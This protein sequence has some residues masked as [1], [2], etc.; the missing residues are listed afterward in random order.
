[1]QLQITITFLILLV[2]ALILGEWLSVAFVIFIGI[3]TL[4][5]VTYG[6][7]KLHQ[8]LRRFLLG[9]KK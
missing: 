2:F 7:G 3:L 4:S 9:R 8:F 6:N 5:I 1:M